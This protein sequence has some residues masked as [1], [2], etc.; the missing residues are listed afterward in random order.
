MSGSSPFLA[1]SSPAEPAP[2]NEKQVD[3]EQPLAEST[4]QASSQP[5]P[6]THRPVK[7]VKMVDRRWL[8]GAWAALFVFAALLAY[9]GI[10]GATWKNYADQIDNV[11]SELGTTVAQLRTDLAGT[12]AELE[13]VHTQLATAQTRI[14]ELANEKAQ[15]GD[16][17]EF[18]KQLLEYQQ[19]ISVAGGTV[20]SKLTTCIAGL[21]Q[22]I[23]V[24]QTQPGG[25]NSAGNDS[26]QVTQLKERVDK[27]CAEAQSANDNLQ[28]ELQK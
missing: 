4:S 26:S 20:A 7:T 2:A 18:R 5:R 28:K 23:D 19:R 15:V 12:H 8:L 13:V 6:H 22:L 24:L 17:S 27:E 14:S 11:N 10:A 21:R 25:G 16:Q 1:A 3:E 9:V